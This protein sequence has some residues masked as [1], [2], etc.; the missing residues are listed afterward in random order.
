MNRNLNSIELHLLEIEGNA[1][2]NIFKDTEYANQL[3]ASASYLLEVIK[4][5]SDDKVVQDLM[6]SENKNQS[7]KHKCRAFKEEK[8][9]LEKELNTYK[10]AILNGGASPGKIHGTTPIKELRDITNLSGNKR[11]EPCFHKNFVIPIS[12]EIAEEMDENIEMAKKE[13]KEIAMKLGNCQKALDASEKEN[14]RLEGE[15]KNLMNDI[16]TAKATSERLIDENN[17]LAADHADLVR[18][19]NHLAKLYDDIG[20]E[21]LN[22]EASVNSWKQKHD[23]LQKEKEDLLEKN[24]ALLSEINILKETIQENEEQYQDHYQ[25][26]LEKLEIS[27]QSAQLQELDY[28][29]ISVSFTEDRKSALVYA[30][31]TLIHVLPLE[32]TGQGVSLA[33]E[34]EEETLNSPSAKKIVLNKAVSGI[35]SAAG[36]AF[37]SSRSPLN[38]PKKNVNEFSLKVENASSSSKKPEIKKSGG[39]NH[40]SHGNSKCVPSIPEETLIESPGPSDFP[41]AIFQKATHLNSEYF[42]IFG[43]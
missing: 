16:K 40:S 30:N 13:N 8:S 43:F 2:E 31:E 3:Q 18:S 15:I 22:A 28:T 41:D 19:K 39:S 17:R 20:K 42:I 4:Q 38:S 32:D 7:L 6:S 24:K 1:G 29:N 37:K 35:S 34:M 21:L 27:N 33:K 10:S 26:L 36:S 12:W 14:K 25:N 9:S 23:K 5:I 11:N